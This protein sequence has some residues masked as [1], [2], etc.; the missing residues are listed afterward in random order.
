M[1]TL[2]HGD[3]SLAVQHLQKALKARGAT[4]IVDGIYGDE[5]EKAVR[6]YQLG[7]GLVVDGIAAPKTQL[8]LAGGD[9]TPLLKNADLVSAA[10]RLG[11]QLA[12]LYAVNEVESAGRGFLGNGKPAILFERHVMHRQLGKARAAALA[13]QYPNLVNPRPGGYA[14]GVA[15]HQRLANARRIDD[16][17]ALESTSWGAFQI[18]GY[19]ATALGYASV[20]EFV[21]R[22]HRNESEHFEAF[23]RFIEADPQLHKAIKA[24]KWQDFA[25][26]YNGPAYARN[27]YDVKLERAYQRH[28]AC[29]CGQAA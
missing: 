3:Q 10:K 22:M 17:A 15:E 7:V 28:A 12:A 18:M 20:H 9:C 8:A 21:E 13:A 5:T 6:A 24:R 14:G 23:V 25:K 27:L 29:H 19:H 16:L 4:L 1:N 2:R 11:V 26:R